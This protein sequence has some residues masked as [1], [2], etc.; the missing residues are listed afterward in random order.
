MTA[1]LTFN[2]PEESAEHKIALDGWKWRTVVDDLN[3]YLRSA[4]KYGNDFKSANQ[5]LESTRERLFALMT[6]EGISL[7]EQ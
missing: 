4:L 2:L 7:D 1:Q 6:E 5:A 3:N